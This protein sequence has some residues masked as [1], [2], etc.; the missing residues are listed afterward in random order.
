ML[1]ETEN[2]MIEMYLHFCSHILNLFNKAVK[3]LEGNY[4]TILDI[5]GIM[6]SLRDQLTQRKQDM[7]FGYGTGKKI[8]LLSS[9]EL[10]RKIQ[11]IFLLFIDKSLEYLNKWL[12]FNNTNWLFTLGNIN[13]KSNIE[14]DNIVNIIENLNL[15]RLN[16]DLDNLYGEITLLNQLYNHLCTSKG[17]A[18]LSTAQKWQQVF[19]KSDDNFFNLYKVISFLLSI[20]ATSAF[21]FNTIYKTRDK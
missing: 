2:D 19:S 21:N 8:Q 11:G 9:P 20:P 13:L 3:C 10:T 12:D 5:Y 18:E 1:N 4:I 14:F 17:F 7:F 6:V 15:Q 16:V